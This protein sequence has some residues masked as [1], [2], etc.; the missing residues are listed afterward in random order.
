MCANRLIVAAAG[1]GKTSI[2]V[3][4]TAQYTQGNV[5]ITTF[6][7]AN[8]Q[9][10]REKF[11]KKVGLRSSARYHTDFGIQR[12]YARSHRGSIPNIVNANHC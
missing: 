4:E 6:T 10:I 8:E 3:D 1:S 9:S 2:I 5:L 12:R 7:L 11:I